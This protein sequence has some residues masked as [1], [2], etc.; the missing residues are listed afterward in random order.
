[1]KIQNQILRLLGTLADSHLAKSAL[2]LGTSEV[3]TNEL[4]T[5]V[6]NWL[7]D[8]ENP[9][10]KDLLFEH[11]AR[12]SDENPQFKELVTENFERKRQGDPFRI[13]MLSSASKTSLLNELR[14][15]EVNED[16]QK[17]ERDTG[18]Q[19]DIFLTGSPTMVVNINNS[20]SIGNLALGT[21]TIDTDSFNQS[22]SHTGIDGEALSALLTHAQQV[23]G[24]EEGSELVKEINVVSKEK[25]PKTTK[26]LRG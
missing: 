21:Q 7:G 12:N 8:E 6:L 2:A 11:M 10:V 24:N 22:F 25:D 19:S 18:S 15:L 1:M 4:S 17:I 13:R 14:T 23:L 16:K 26:S 20:G 9:N 5:T 3:K